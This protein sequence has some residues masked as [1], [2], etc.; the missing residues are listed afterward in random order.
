MHQSALVGIELFHE[1]RSAGL[2]HPLGAGAG[3]AQ[4]FGFCAGAVV[5]AIDAYAGRVCPSGLHQ[6]VYHIL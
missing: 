3:A 6:A 2:Q 5:V 4:Q 1:Q